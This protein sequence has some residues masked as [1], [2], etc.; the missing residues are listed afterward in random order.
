MK[1]QKESYRGEGSNF[2]LY[3]VPSILQQLWCGQID[4]NN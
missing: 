2:M 3:Q 4:K 1:M